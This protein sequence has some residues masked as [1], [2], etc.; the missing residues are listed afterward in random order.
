MEGQV[1]TWHKALSNMKKIV[2]KQLKARQGMAEDMDK[3]WKGLCP[4]CTKCT[5][6]KSLPPN[7]DF[8]SLDNSAELECIHMYAD[9][10]DELV[11]E[12]AKVE[13]RYEHGDSQAL[14]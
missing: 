10:V 14:L 13:I 8:G 3:A 7:H 11:A 1:A 6:E 5:T 9:M 2:K 12:L 4:R